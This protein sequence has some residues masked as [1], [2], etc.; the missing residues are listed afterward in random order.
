CRLGR[1][2]TA[3]SGAETSETWLMTPE[4]ILQ[5][6]KEIEERYGP[7]VGHNYWLTDDVYAVKKSWGPNQRLRRMVQVVAD[8]AG[9]P[10]AELRVLDLDCLEG[11]FALEFALQGAQV[12]GIEGRE[13][14]L[15]RARFAAEVYG[16]TGI[17]FIQGDVRNLTPES[18]GLFDV[19]LC[20]GILYLLDAPDVFPF[21]EPASA[22]CRPLPLID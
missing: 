17:E 7:W 1:N 15:A 20:L 2:S 18:Y 13:A 8:L 14:N 16:A 12:L 11:G 4:Q 9:K 6:K 3:A 5:G 22:V 10:L 19:V 21:L